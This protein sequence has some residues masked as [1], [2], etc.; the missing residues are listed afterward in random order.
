MTAMSTD[1]E[2]S[3]AEA[4]EAADWAVRHCAPAALEAAGH[5][6]W[7]AVLRALGRLADRASTTAARGVTAE[8][9]SAAAHH[10][11]AADAAGE[12]RA[13]VF[14]AALAAGRAAQSAYEAA[15]LN[16]DRRPL[17]ALAAA[18]DAAHAAD[19]AARDAAQCGLALGVTDDQVAWVAAGTPAAIVRALFALA[20][21]PPPTPAPTRS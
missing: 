13:L 11:P 19:A 6:S 8:I 15:H 3:C 9:S 16:A 4:L 10:G 5:P 2:P 7:A 18:F 1:A 21:D 17:A 14:G 20:V 12:R